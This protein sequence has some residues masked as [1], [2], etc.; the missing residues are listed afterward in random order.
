MVPTL[1]PSGDIVLTESISVKRGWFQRGD[2]VVAR[3]PNKPT[4][5]VCK[6]IAGMP[7]DRVCVNP[8]KYPR[9]FTTVPR[10]HV[11]LQGDNVRN[12]TDSRTYGA[13]PVPLLKSRVVFKCWPP[14]EAGFVY[15]SAVVVALV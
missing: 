9:R 5:Y 15:R 4:V 7:G 6:R 1:N 3:S 14:L 2:V 8:T 11:W 12:S 10:N 13:V